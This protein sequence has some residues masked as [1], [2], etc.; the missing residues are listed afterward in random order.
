MRPGTWDPK[1]HIDDMNVAGI[2]TSVCFPTFAGFCGSF[3]WDAKDKANAAGVVAA[4]NDW[5]IDEWCGPYPGRYLPTAILPLWDIEATLRYPNLRISLSEGGIGWIPY[6]LERCDF[7]Y[8]H[9]GAWVR[10]AWGG[11]LP[12]EVFR[13]HSLCCFIDD[14][15]GC[16]NY[17]DV[18]E[19][20]IAYE[21]DDPHS[22]CTWP[23]CGPRRHTST[24]RSAPWGAKMPACR[25][26]RINRS[27][28]GVCGPPRAGAER[29]APPVRTQ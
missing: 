27:L 16:R 22:D 15:S 8:R 24:R 23:R 9:H 2:L 29:R 13:E 18:G 26:V 25:A 4:H 28:R 10:C 1:L 20:I 17:A 21:C 14:K 19:D 6:F 5:R 3:F 7:T 11:K 12:S